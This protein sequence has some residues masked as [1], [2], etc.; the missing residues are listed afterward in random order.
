MRVNVYFIGFR[1]KL[2]LKLKS[3]AINQC[4]CD[5]CLLILGLEREGEREKKRKKRSHMVSYKMFQF[6]GGIRSRKKSPAIPL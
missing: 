4:E 6:R 5:Q 3:I 1:S 2:I